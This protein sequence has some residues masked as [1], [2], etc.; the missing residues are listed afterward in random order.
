MSL[1]TDFVLHQKTNQ[2]LYHSEDKRLSSSLR[3]RESYWCQF[4]VSYLCSMCIIFQHDPSFDIIDINMILMFYLGM[5]YRLRRPFL[6]RT[7]YS[8]GSSTDKR[9]SDIWSVSDLR[10]VFS[11]FMSDFSSSFHFVTFE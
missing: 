5:L 4:L 7:R 9:L 1:V 11:M 8:G 10:E 6:D 3:N 2:K